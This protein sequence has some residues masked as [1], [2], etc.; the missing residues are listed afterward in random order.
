MHRTVPCL[1]LL[2]LAALG[3]AAI[4]DHAKENLSKPV[5]CE[6]AVHDIETL[7]AGRA[8]S[9]ARIAHGVT[10]IIPVSAV[11]GIASGGEGDRI[12]VASGAFNTSIDQKIAEIRETCG[13]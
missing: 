3:C 11:I 5:N 9:A 10:A 1:C 7:E 8:S 6:T 4:P 12:R 2:L 13:L